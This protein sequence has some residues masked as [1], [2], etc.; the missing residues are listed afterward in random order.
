MDELENVT[1]DW[2]VMVKWQ[3]LYSKEADSE[4]HHPL[5]GGQT[6]GP[7]SMS[8]DTLTAP[9]DDASIKFRPFYQ[10]GILWYHRYD[11]CVCLKS[12]RR[13]LLWSSCSHSPL[14]GEVLLQDPS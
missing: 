12:S 9:W 1:P 7:L 10:L 13:L 11:S 14:Q 6:C 4:E 8:W 2:L 3:D 5:Q